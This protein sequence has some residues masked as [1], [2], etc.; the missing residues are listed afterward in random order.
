MYALGIDIG[1]ST[2]CAVVVDCGNKALGGGA[3][4]SSV[5][6]G[7]GWEEAA[8]QVRGR[9]EAAGQA[10]AGALDSGALDSGALDSGAAGSA[11]ASGGAVVVD[12]ATAPNSSHIEGA[13]YEDLQDPHAILDAVLRV[14]GELCAKHNPVGAIGL[15]CQM[16]G[17]VYTD[18]S[19]NAVSPLYTWQDGRGGVIAPEGVSYVKELEAVSGHSGLA[20]GY[21]AVTHYYN[22]RNRLI[23]A[24]AVGFCPIGDYVAMQLTGRRDCATHMSNAASLA[25]YDIDSGRFDA[26]AIAKAG[27]DPAFFPKVET[28][29]AL[30]GKTRNGQGGA[31]AGLGGTREESGGACAGL[32]GSSREF[33]LIPGGIPVGFCIGD[34]QASFI[35]SVAAPDSMVLVN[36][37]TGGQISAAGF[38]AECPPGIDQRPLAGD[39]YLQ[40][41]STLCGGRA[42]AA[43]EKFFSSVLR[44]AGVAEPSPDALYNAMGA[45]LDD[46]GEA[47]DADPLNVSVRFCGTRLE[48]GLRGS[49]TNLGLGNFTPAHLVSGVLSGIADEF[50]ELYGNMRD[51]GARDTLVGSGNG[52][53][54]NIRLRRKISERFGMPLLITEH[55]EE[56]SFGCALFALTAGGHFKSLREAQ[57]QIRY[58]QCK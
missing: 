8:R 46:G 27:M 13:E 36:V 42:Y 18:S 48:P 20:S 30:F 44:M 6:E 58:A 28:G 57:K 1:T 2:I 3:V 5:E 16:H 41:G 43:L 15:S 25:L 22:T 55:G 32:G 23:P 47:V 9:E 29:C 12:T 14:A 39:Y 10:R 50:Y 4:S 21:G 34:N 38:R 54:K 51:R 45:L 40:A 35:G 52:L 19:G 53:R 49:I 37:G 17:I 11:A 24:G 7:G 33:G 56:A 31:C 26:A